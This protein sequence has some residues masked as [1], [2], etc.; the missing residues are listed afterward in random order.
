MHEASA[1]RRHGASRPAP[2]LHA[3]PVAQ[4]H[5]APRQVLGRHRHGQPYA[6]VV[7]SGCYEEAGDPGRRRLDAGDVVLHDA[8]SAHVNRVGARGARLLNLPWSGG[9]ERFA[10][11]RDPDAVL[12]LAARDPHAAVQALHEGLQPLAPALQDWPDLLARDL[13]S[14]PALSLAD[15]ARRHGL[16]A[17][18]LSRG[19]ARVFGV[20]P[21]RWRFEL[22]TRRALS[23]LRDGRPS[24]VGVAFDAGFADQAHLTHA[25]VALT[26]HAPGHWRP[27]SSRDK[28]A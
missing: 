1:P 20:T 26:G 17:E 7:L 19:F 10:R 2:P 13:A 8:F 4:Q 22:R 16:A 15:W 9:A 25:V 18:T 6:A 14:E 27:T 5:L 24:L 12:R 23:A 21:R 3:L 28:T 11:L